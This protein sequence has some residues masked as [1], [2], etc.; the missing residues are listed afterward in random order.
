MGVPVEST[1]DFDQLAVAPGP[2]GS[3]AKLYYYQDGSL[4][5]LDAAGNDSPL[6]STKWRAPAVF[7]DTDATPLV[8]P[9]KTDPSIAGLSWGTQVQSGDLIVRVSDGEV[10]KWNQVHSGQTKEFQDLGYAIGGG[11]TAAPNVGSNAVGRAH[12]A[13]TVALAT[14]WQKVPIDTADFGAANFD[15]VTNH[16]YTAPYSGYYRVAAQ[17][18]ITAGAV[19]E[20]YALAVYK[21][22][23]Q[24]FEGE[25][26]WSETTAAAVYGLEGDDLVFLNVGDY[27]ELW[28]YQSGSGGSLF[29]GGAANNYLAV[30]FV[31]PNTPA[32]V[33]PNTAAR[34]YR[35]AAL[36][37]A[38]GAWVAIPLDTVTRDP[39]GH[40][41]LTNGAYV[42]PAAG[43]YTVDGHVEV[44]LTTKGTSL[45][46]GAG[47]M[48]N[49]AL[50][51]ENV[52][53]IS[54]Q[55]SSARVTVS[56]T[57]YCNLG[58]T[59]QLA[60][61][62]DVAHPLNVGSPFV[63]LSVVMVDQAVPQLAPQ[64]TAARAYHN[65]SAWALP[66]L[67]TWEV[68]PIDTV[69]LDA[70]S[71]MDVTTN[72][73]YNV[74]TP[75]WYQVNAQVSTTSEPVGSGIYVGILKNGGCV[76]Q[77]VATETTSGGALQA[78]VSD[79]VYCV[80]GDRIQLGAFSQST[81]S[82]AA[83][84]GGLYNCLS[85]VK[86][87]QPSAVSSTSAPPA[88]WM[89]AAGGQ[90]FTNGQQG[91][92]SM[93][94]PPTLKNGMTTSGGGLKV[95]IGGT[96]QVNAHLTMVTPTGASGYMQAQIAV[97]NVAVGNAQDTANP[98]QTFPSANSSRALNLNAGDVVSYYLYNAAGVTLTVNAASLDVT[99]IG[100]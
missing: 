92:I 51:S 48:V 42:V 49:G 14:G 47:I 56:D 54:D 17:V 3:G 98:N 70:G 77:A 63:Y 67:S 64:N 18:L 39:G 9:A 68:V 20:Q 52:T 73:C 30:S 13:A 27:L 40:F 26:T 50:V 58:D 4:H 83:G 2:P 46:T 78:V 69:G 36:T 38:A 23:A 84:G 76:A 90:T 33:A 94:N 53:G 41:N 97:N 29:A 10:F 95:P 89:S 85:V 5:T 86:V 57:I 7:F 28:V 88:G 75:G 25:S 1:L 59:I 60:T 74:T 34:A 19:G 15:L 91:M 35:A 44:N 79:L 8:A 80:P 21:N 71:H 31:A 22:G 87:D 24:A 6:M 93:P 82:L 66:A 81:V 62:M 16:R 55:Y 100:P 96:Y 43:W 99:Y 72:H 37:P 61:I 45:S 32:S 11:V 65:G 12:R